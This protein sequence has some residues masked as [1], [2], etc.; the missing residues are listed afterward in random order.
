MSTVIIRPP[1]DIAVFVNQSAVFECETSGGGLQEWRVNG[2]L[3]QYLLSDVR[4][5]MRTSC[6]HN[7]NKLTIVARTK[8][9]G[10]TV[11]CLIIV[12]GE[13]IIVESDIATLEIQAVQGEY[14][15]FHTH[16]YI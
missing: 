16:V 3:Y 7:T 15:Y 5:D 13:G 4:E 9:N 14:L 10:T 12:I 11:Q 2:T 6:V 1:V 8:Y